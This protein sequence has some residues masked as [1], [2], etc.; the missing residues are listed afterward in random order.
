MEYFL[1]YKLQQYNISHISF[2]GQPN[3]CVEKV[4][5]IAREVLW[6]KQNSPTST[7]LHL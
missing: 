4:R 2:N 7:G 6:R 3:N 5:E 1:I